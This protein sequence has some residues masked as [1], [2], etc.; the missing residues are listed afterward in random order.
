MRRRCQMTG[1]LP[2]LG[3][4][5]AMTNLLRTKPVSPNQACHLLPKVLC[6]FTLRL[7][8]LK[9][10]I[11][12]GCNAESSPQCMEGSRYEIGFAHWTRSWNVHCVCGGLFA[13]PFGIAVLNKGWCISDSCSETAHIRRTSSFRWSQWLDHVP[14]AFPEQPVHGY[15]RVTAKTLA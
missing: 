7:R 12:D 3:F 5:N 1:G 4:A 11:G 13:E 8:A 15:D 9:I 10:H 6:L 14:F 2:C